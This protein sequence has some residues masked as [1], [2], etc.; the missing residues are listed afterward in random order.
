MLIAIMS[1]SHDH[2]ANLE[3]AIILARQGGA[4]MIIH[5]GDYVAPFSLKI[6]G[7]AGLPVHGVFGNNDGDQYLL[8]RLSMSELE[9]ITLHG[10][11][12]TLEIDN[13]KIAF[14]HLPLVGHGLAATEDYDLVCFGHSHNHHARHVGS[15]LLL[16]PGEIMGKDESAGF[17]IYDTAKDSFQRLLLK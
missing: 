9:L 10:Q 13:T 4:E 11:V 12:G 2:L 14:T 15:T 3:K 5:C 8:T 17:C 16:N 7:N 1:D 6:L